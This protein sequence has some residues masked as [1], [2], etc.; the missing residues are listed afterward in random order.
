MRS[1]VNERPSCLYLNLRIW[2]AS[3][4]WGER[5]FRRRAHVSL[6]EEKARSHGTEDACAGSTSMAR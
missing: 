6:L 2:S 3:S 5:L 1:E 4:S